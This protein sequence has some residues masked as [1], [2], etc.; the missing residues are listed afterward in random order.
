MHRWSTPSRLHQP[1][2]ADL[3]AG[4]LG[5]TYTASQMTYQLRRLRLHGPNEM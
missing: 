4:L 5:T 2:P 1:E 3:V